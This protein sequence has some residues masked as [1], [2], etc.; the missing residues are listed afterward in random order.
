MITVELTTEEMRT[1]ASVG[2]E[3]RLRA[4]A[5]GRRHR[6]DWSGEGEWGVDINAAA[7]ELAVAKVLGRYWVDTANTD[8]DGDVGPGVQVRWT[9]RANGRLLLHPDD[10]D[11]HVFVLVCGTMPA[12][13]IPGWIRGRDG[14]R[15][16]WWRQDTGRPAFFVPREAL[17]SL[18]ARQ[19]A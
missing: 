13:T 4:V 9:A 2:V 14:K 5:R 17:A 15:P 1:A 7:A 3:R 10:G 8:F 16:E 18:A 11:T 12:F 6:H 19:A